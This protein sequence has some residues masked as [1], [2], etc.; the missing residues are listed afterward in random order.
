MKLTRRTL[1]AASAATF[2]LPGPLRADPA[3]LSAR[4]GEATLLPEGYGATRIWGFDGT[5][6]GPVLRFRQGDRL[7]RRF[8][9]DLDQASTVHW[10]GLRLPNAMDGVPGVTQEPVAPGAQFDYAFDL[11][12]AG[13]FWY[14]PHD[15][16]WEQ[17]GRGMAGALIVEEDTPPETDRDEILLVQDWRL[18]DSGAMADDFGTMH[19]WAHG[20]RIGNWL[21]VNGRPAG[22]QPAGRHD[23]LRLR[24]VNAATARVLQVARRGLDGWVIARDGQPLERPQ[25]L[26]DM[27]TIGPGSRA[28]LLVDVTAAAGERAGLGHAE[29][30]GLSPLFLLDVADGGRTEPLGVPEPLPPNDMPALGPLDAAQQAELRMAGGAMGGLS[31]AT[32]DG[33]ERRFGELARMGKLWAFNGAVDMDERPLLRVAPGETVRVALRNDTAWP[34]AMHLHGHH[35][36]RLDDTGRPGPLGDTITL[37]PRER[38]EIAFVAESPGDWLLHCHM[39]SHAASGM[40]THIRVG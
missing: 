10:H 4:E 19:D 7:V 30:D 15:R 12:D 32:L 13:T 17:V 33:E 26:S 39:L 40:M 5:A 20:G 9:N 3:P 1:L 29:R 24:I 6:P 21:T 18:Y 11:R 2:A 28:D 38:A 8:V 16:A 36:R 23:R 22:A 37:A 31:T 35:F 27:L 25:E 14:H 34:H